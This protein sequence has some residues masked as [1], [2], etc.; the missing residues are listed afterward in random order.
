M[1]ND[2][3]PEDKD[4]T[5]FQPCAKG[6]YWRMALI[7]YNHEVRPYE[8]G[9]SADCKTM[10]PITGEQLCDLIGT[11][12]FQEAVEDCETKLAAWLAKFN[13][14]DPRKEPAHG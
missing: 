10:M 11:E 14:P 4:F 5:L 1:E 7:Y 3:Y 2:P 9:Y 6:G 12:L 8:Y 13:L